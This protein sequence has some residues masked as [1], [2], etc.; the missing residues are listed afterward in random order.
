[1]RVRLLWAVNAWSN[2]VG[3]NRDL[4]KISHQFNTRNHP[5]HQDFPSTIYTLLCS[6][7]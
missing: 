4:G 7:K 6:T 2:P 5:A 1:M 3:I